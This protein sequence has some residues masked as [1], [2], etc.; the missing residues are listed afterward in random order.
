M[1]IIKKKSIYI[2]FAF[3]FLSFLI[4]QP[5]NVYSQ[6]DW[7]SNAPYVE[8]VTP[9]DG[10]TSV[11]I[12]A[13]IYVTFSEPMYYYSTE[14]AFSIYPPIAFTITSNYLNTVFSLQY[15][16][17]LSYGTTYEVT[18]DANA[19]DPALNTLQ[20]TPY[21]WSFVTEGNPWSHTYTIDGLSLDENNVQALLGADNGDVWVALT[22]G[23]VFR[24]DGSAF[25]SIAE[26]LGNVYDF[27]QDSQGNIW[28]ASN[29]GIH[30]SDGTAWTHYNTGNSDLS[31]DNIT[32]IA[33]DSM[34]QVWAGTSTSGLYLFDGLTWTNYDTTVPNGIS[35][36]WVTAV[37]ADADDLIWIGTLSGDIDS[38]DPQTDTWT[39]HTSDIFTQTSID[40][41]FAVR[42]IVSSPGRIWV[43][44]TA[45]LLSYDPA[46]DSWSL[47]NQAGGDLLN[48]SCDALVWKPGNT[49]WIGTPDGINTFDGTVWDYV[50]IVE[51]GP[52]VLKMTLDAY[53][54]I[55]MGTIDTVGIQDSLSTYDDDLPSVLSTAPSA[56]QKNVSRSTKIKITFSEPMD[57]DSVLGALSIFP[58]FAYTTSWDAHFSILTIT[59][60]SK[61]SYSRKYTISLTTAAS[62]LLE[63]GL[64]G[65]V[66]WSFT[67]VKQSSTTTTTPGFPST[68]L[69]LPS[70]SPFGL[71]SSLSF[72][73]F[74]RGLP[75][76]YSFGGPSLPSSLMGLSGLSSLYS[77][78]L[79][80]LTSRLGV[81]SFNL[82]RS[83]FFTFPS[84]LS[85]LSNLY[86]LSGLSNFRKLY[87]F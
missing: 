43:G 76:S 36:N 1:C 71:S 70:T 75:T 29:D 21:V 57:P 73:S 39:N 52:G 30:V 42:E 8:E 84:G 23:D 66:S 15:D 56:N 50:P 87:G 37:H 49:L 47:F 20:P 33:T 67:T 25:Q 28:V 53:G 55:W 10:Q 85:N 35:D 60:S 3:L 86:S 2:I 48:D 38:F 61:L 40:S 83:S 41:I 44:S 17:F 45:G 34:D 31:D 18:I 81:S 72:L 27:A 59:P 5:R 62:D 4:S 46:L 51:A 19:K 64:P 14:Y 77:R 78:N 6:I 79:Y 63:N 26:S 80:S 13:P 68:G 69:N 58:S 32:C 54:H 16:M 11:P 9:Q 24:F 7:D 65:S 22:S 82:P 12:D 74:S